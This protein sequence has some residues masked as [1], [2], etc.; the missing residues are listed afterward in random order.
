MSVIGRTRG[1]A[2]TSP[3]G[4]LPAVPASARRL[5]DRFLATVEGWE[6]GCIHCGLPAPVRTLPRSAE[7]VELPLCA[8]HVRWAMACRREGMGKQSH[9]LRG[10]VL[11]WVRLKGGDR[12]AAIVWLNGHDIAAPDSASPSATGAQ[13][14]NDEL[15]GRY[16][17]ALLSTL[18]PEARSAVSE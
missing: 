2:V 5:K 11:A 7:L 3:A 14:V 18:G 10:L 16:A 17:E 1:I 9:H 6:S 8:K 13:A 4:G 15:A 12:H